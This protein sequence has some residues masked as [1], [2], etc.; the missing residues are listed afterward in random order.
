MSKAKRGKSASTNELSKWES[1]LHQA[2]FNEVN[3]VTSL[4][5]AEVLQISSTF[6]EICHVLRGFTDLNSPG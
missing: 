2:P 4:K 1:E 6:Y 3:N 5:T